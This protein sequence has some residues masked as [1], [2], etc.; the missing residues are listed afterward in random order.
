M[1]SERIRRRIENLLDEA[2]E[3]YARRDWA[4]AEDRANTALGLAP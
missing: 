1:P 3:V 4:V 2:D